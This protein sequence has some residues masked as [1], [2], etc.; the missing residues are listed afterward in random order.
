M[1]E[2][3]ARDRPKEDAQR[4]VAAPGQPKHGACSHL[5][6]FV[7]FQ[8]VPRGLIPLTGAVGGGLLGGGIELWDPA[9]FWMVSMGA[10]AVGGLAGFLMWL[11]A[12]A[13][14][15]RDSLFYLIMFA[16]LWSYAALFVLVLLQAGLRAITDGW[17][18]RPELA[19]A[20]AAVGCAAGLAAQWW[21]GSRAHRTRGS[22]SDIP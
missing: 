5:A 12:L 11:T 16:L 9:V 20:G 2:E 7:I 4:S 14:K 18:G 1:S 10:V 13:P 19:L 8:A 15:L 3:R 22:S 21:Y 6:A 17:G